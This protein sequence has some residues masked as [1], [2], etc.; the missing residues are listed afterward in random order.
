MQD[1]FINHPY[2]IY[3]DHLKTIREKEF[4]SRELDIIAC[5]VCGRSATISSFLSISPKTVSAHISNILQKISGNSR[6]DIISFIEKSNQYFLVKEYYQS[7]IIYFSFETFLI[8]NLSPLKSINP[9]K[10]TTNTRS[11]LKE[12]MVFIKD[13]EKHLSLSDIKISHP[14]KEALSKLIDYIKLNKDECLILNL[15][16]RELELIRAETNSKIL[17]IKNLSQNLSQNQHNSDLI[18]IYGED[19]QELKNFDSINFKEYDNYYLGVFNILKKISSTIDLD[20]LSE[21][22]IQLAKTLGNTSERANTD[23]SPLRKKTFLA[24]PFLFIEFLKKNPLRLFLSVFSLIF[25]ISCFTIFLFHERHPSITNIDKNTTVI[26]SDLLIPTESAFLKRSKTISDIAKKLE[27]K[28]GIPAIALVGITGIGGVG[29]TTLARYYAQSLSASVIWEINAETKESLINSFKDLAYAFAKTKDQ[30]DELAFIQQVQTQ[31]EKEKQLLSFIKNQLKQHPNWFLIYDNVESFSSIK[32]FFP[33]DPEVWGEGKVIITTRDSNIQNTSHIK[34]DNV[35]QIEE[36]N[37]DESLTL[38]CKILYSVKPNQ[39]TPEQRENTLAFLTNIPPFPLDISIAAYYIKSA[40]ISYAQYLERVMQYSESFEK[41]QEFLV[42]EISDYSKTRY[43]IITL[44]FKKLIETNPEFKALLLLSCFLDSQNILR[45]LFEHYKDPTV[46]E[47]FLYHLRKYS[48][49]TTKS[50]VAN[51]NDGTNFFLHRSTQTIGQAFLLNILTQNELVNLID[52]IILS[53]GSF[54]KTFSEK[55]SSYTFLLIPHLETLLKNLNSLPLSRELK[56]KY[57]QDLL[58]LLGYIHYKDSRNYILAKK[59][60]SQTYQMNK[61]NKNFSN[62]LMAIILKDLGD[63]C[64]ILGIPDEALVYSQESLKICSKVSNSETSIAENLK[65]IGFAYSLKNKSNEAKHY[66]ENALKTILQIDH[67]QKKEIESR[68]YSNLATF[69]SQTY[70]SQK[71]GYEA[72]TYALKALELVNGSQT[73]YNNPKEIQKKIPCY[74]AKHKTT[75]GQVHNHLGQYKEGLI[76]GFQEAQYIIDNSVNNCAYALLKA[77]VARGMG[78]SLLR[79]GKLNEAKV[80]LTEALQKAE[81]LLG[82]NDTWIAL[83]AKTFRAEILIRSGNFKEAYEDCQDV[84]NM[85]RKTKTNYSELIYLTSYYHAAFIQYKLG[86][87]KKSLEHFNDFFKEIRAFSELFFDKDTYEN[88][89]KKRSFAE[90]SYNEEKA[91]DD[92]N[93]CLSRS[94]TIF[95]AIYNPSHP[96]VKDYILKN[97]PSNNGGFN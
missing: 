66:L 70:M 3:L 18:L 73:Y 11:Q 83:A 94:V 74:I 53:I 9:K 52:S 64:V 31:E 20:R 47:N 82:A 89:E 15:S 46:V 41:T 77:R 13:L 19:S 79:L 80:K 34:P 69:Y 12:S 92:I 59:Y 14:K 97:L 36:L 8:K 72:I 33:R 96:F 38:F 65:N 43:G 23:F 24:S 71:N 78:E 26:R 75:L 84:F 7:L 48:L 88:L 62:E 16:E 63:I 95:S 42:K 76:K 29:K 5:I 22:F 93:Q 85:E 58:Y 21:E 28:Q 44:S 61:I 1:V 30:R 39:L 4:T 57:E 37:Q 86:N 17:I 6:E 67:I 91:A 60:L 27:E 87:L 32:S 54:Y 25:G 90:V 10:N 49:I 50:Q 81:K 51:K 55:G 68:I 35:I 56:E 40:R 2:N 45:D